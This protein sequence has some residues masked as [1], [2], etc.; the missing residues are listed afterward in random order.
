MNSKLGYGLAACVMILFVAPVAVADSTALG[1]D[2][3]G[4][5]FDYSQNTYSLGWKFTVNKDI[6]VTAL[7]FYDD[8]KN[9]LTQNH[10][11][12]I[13][14]MSCQLVASTT[15]TPADA[16]TGFFRFHPIEPVN[17]QAGTDYYIAAVTGD[18]NYA[19]N[20]TTLNV[21]PAI[22][23]I[24]FSIF[25]ATQTTNELKCPNG[26]QSANFNGD[27]G[28]SFQFRDADD[29]NPDDANKRGTGIS[30]F[31]NRRGVN[32]ETA[33]CSASVADRGAPPRSLPTGAINF[34]ATDGFS[35]GTAQC[36]IQQTAYSPGI[37]ACE[38][39]FSV[40]SGFPIGAKFPID[41]S[42]VGDANFKTSATSHKLII[43]ACV[44]TAEKPCP[45]AIGLSFEGYPKLLQNKIAALL[46][47][48]SG[49]SDSRLQGIGIMAE[50]E[51]P[52]GGVCSV[53]G[54]V[55]VSVKNLFGSLNFE[56]AVTIG[57]QISDQEA[58]KDTLLYYIKQA[59][60]LETEE[61]WKIMRETQEAIFKIQQEVNKNR[62]PI[63]NPK[64]NPWEE[65]I[66]SK[67]SG[68]AI[69][70]A[71]NAAPAIDKSRK[72]KPISVDVKRDR[73]KRVNFKLSKRMKN[74]AAVFKRA[75]MTTL[76]LDISLTAKQKNRQ[77]AAKATD[78][79]DVA[80]E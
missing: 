15:V 64:G 37:G 71:N 3:L 48:G 26:S 35:P 56:E 12:G 22:N 23:F 77:G 30:L 7:G 45:N 31:C 74:L 75:G 53:K 52:A 72:S 47:C 36:S 24:G 51:I 6:S 4:S 54:S 18:E 33:V 16:L 76:R 5:G 57:E 62:I 14:D 2:A 13:Y 41:A 17:L 67:V 46:S 69:L 58:Q 39:T 1:F 9:G 44:S 43:P 38:V 8:L 28:P 66:K 59:H 63:S 73:Q 78:T 21:D 61:R 20:V 10:D 40:P 55:S 34:V 79:V 70:S 80:I 11:V 42:Y 29:E 65:F 68:S 49:K 19:V 25:G 60:K 50:D 27:F 32:L